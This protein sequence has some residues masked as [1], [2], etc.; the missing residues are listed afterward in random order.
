MNAE[1][2]IEHQ[3]EQGSSATGAAEAMLEPA[4]PIAR[5]SHEV[6]DQEFEQ[7]VRGALEVVEGTLL[8]KMKTSVDGETQHAAAAVVGLGEGRQFLLLTLPATGGQ[9][10]VETA[11]HSRSP[12]AGIAESYAGLMDVLKA[13]A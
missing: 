9:L 2:S 12:L 1:E 6:S 3:P 10:K 4:I 11:S 5:I 8:F 7:V 13:A